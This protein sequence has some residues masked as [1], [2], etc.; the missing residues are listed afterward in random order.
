MFVVDLNFPNL[1]PKSFIKLTTEESFLLRAAIHNKCLSVTYFGEA[2][3]K[4]WLNGKKSNLSKNEFL[5]L[6]L[7]LGKKPKNDQVFDLSIYSI[8]LKGR[9]FESLGEKSY[10]A[11]SAADGVT[12]P[13]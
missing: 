13:R 12:D 4:S 9:W 5:G 10:K 11:Q 7:G 2:Q 8:N 3:K 1:P 6:N